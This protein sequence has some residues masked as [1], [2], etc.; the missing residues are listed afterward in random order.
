MGIYALDH[1]YLF[2]IP[3]LLNLDS[4]TLLFLGNLLADAKLPRKATNSAHFRTHCV[5]VTS[6]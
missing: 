5:A 3:A 6:T 1:G 2:P 4:Y